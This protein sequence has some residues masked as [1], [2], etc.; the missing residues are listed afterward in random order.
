MPVL[1]AVEVDMKAKLAEAQP[2]R[3][4]M[5]WGWRIRAVGY[6]RQSM[7][8]VKRSLRSVESQ[9]ENIGCYAENNGWVLEEV[10]QDLCCSGDELLRPALLELLSR[11]D[12]DVLLVDTAER[13]TRRK[14]DLDLILALLSKRNITCVCATR[15]WDFWSQYMRRHYRMQENPL[16]A[17][18]DVCVV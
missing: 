12:F 6:V 10:Y 9:T 17:Y 5:P 14:K 18:G 4:R 3:A 15:S 8:E 1:H 7:E 16:Y 11:L 13:L 2:P